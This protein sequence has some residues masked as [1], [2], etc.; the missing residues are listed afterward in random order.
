MR[1]LVIVGVIDRVRLGVCVTLAVWEGLIV[2]EGVG[3][4]VAPWEAVRLGLSD[5]VEEPEGVRAPDGLRVV[6]CVC[7]GDRVTVVLMLGVSVPLGAWDSVCVDVRG[8]EPLPACES[9]SVGL[10]V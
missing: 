5:G 6:L 3:L 4:G 10:I 9:V 2:P 8:C 7:V 1:V